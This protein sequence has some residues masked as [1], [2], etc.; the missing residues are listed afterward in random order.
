MLQQQQ[1]SSKSCN[2]RRRQPVT[3]ILS[4]AILI[5]SAHQLVKCYN[6]FVHEIKYILEIM[7]KVVPT[8]NVLTFKKLVFIFRFQLLRLEKFEIRML[9]VT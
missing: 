4:T 5:V 9:I 3:Y 7:L 2:H 1:V 6:M 8:K